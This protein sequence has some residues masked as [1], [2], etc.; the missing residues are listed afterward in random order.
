MDFQLA[1]KDLLVPEEAMIF[2]NGIFVSTY[3]T[4]TQ[5]SNF[6]GV[7]RSLSAGFSIGTQGYIGTGDSSNIFYYDF[8]EYDSGTNTWTQKAN[9]GG[10]F[11]CD[12]V[13][14]SIGNKGYIGTGVNLVSVCQYFWE[15]T[16][17]STA[18]INELSL[19]NFIS[20]YPNPFAETATLQI[21]NPR[22]ANYEL[23]LF[24]IKG[25]KLRGETI[26][27]SSSFVIRGEGLPCGVYFLHIIAGDRQAV[28]KI[29]ISD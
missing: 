15:F 23:K 3:N 24:D 11:S 16:P 18:G 9:F 27:N 20:I 13:G 29:I 14:F 26:R 19:N 10:G 6:P 12:G 2:V 17:D 22:I 8:W 25:N 5:K 28:K 21:T 7:A 4:W 1:R